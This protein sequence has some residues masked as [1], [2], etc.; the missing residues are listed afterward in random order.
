MQL[1]LISY[2]ALV[3]A[4]LMAAET[5]QITRHDYF[6]KVK[7]GWTGK[8]L[9]L[10]MGVAKESSEPWPPSKFEYFAEVPTHFSDRQSG[11]DVYVPLVLQLALKKYGLHPTQEQY[12]N[13]WSERLFTGKIWVACEVA[14]DHFRAGLKPP[15]TGQPG[16]NRYWDDM[17][18][19][20]STDVIGWIAPG[21]M[22]TAAQ[23]GDHASHLINWGSG[24]DGGVFTAAID[25]EA[26]FTRDPAEL[27]RRARRV[28]PAG[29]AYGKMIDYLLDLRSREP[30]WRV[31]RQSLAQYLKRTSSL[32]ISPEPFAGMINGGA[33]VI[34][35]LYGD[36]D[37]GKSLLISQKCG[38]DSDTNASTAGGILG[39]MLGLSRLEP[40]W[41]LVLHD[42]YENYCIRGLPRWMRFSDIAADTVELGEQAI[43]ENGGSVSGGVYTIPLQAAAPLG[44]QEYLTP[45]LLQQKQSEM[46]QFYR[47]KLH[48]L[49]AKWQPEWTLTMAAF[50]NRP[51]VLPEYF[52]RRNVLKV[53][54]NVYGAVLERTVA[55]AA[56]KHHYLRAGVANHPAILVE[57]TGQR[58]NGG[59]R[60]E[61]NVDGKPAG[62]YDV[63]TRD[64]TVV[65]EDPEFDLT[66][67]AGK[68]V[69]V[70]LTALRTR[71]GDFYRLSHTGYWSEIELRALDKP[72]PWR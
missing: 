9:G 64:G 5:R 43:R 51:K 13:E 69:K 71:G 1:K 62:A 17:C 24:A 46:A 14:L 53:Q 18:S 19:Q 28:L 47:E 59:W 10:A 40:R 67:W 35:V 15:K 30:D 27:V 65:W 22:Q 66:A 20:M 7:G 52:G 2:L 63:I 38:W 44:R 8:A 11:D 31:A 12:L 3:P 42:T 49:T 37:F 4:V 16:F 32:N 26:F 68:T 56:G 55:L 29:S 45:E 50:E 6:D 34:A 23:M 58:I 54:P 21:M 72:E 48:G 70:T 33:V 36:G 61:V 39:T 41:R 57:A 25:S 60:L